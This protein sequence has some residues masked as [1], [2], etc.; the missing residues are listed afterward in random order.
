MNY[1]VEISGQA[2]VDL[3]RVLAALHERSPM[4][5]SRLARKFWRSL[6]RLRVFPLA[7]GL[8]HESDAFPEEVRHLLFGLR[9]GRKYRALFVV[10]G[11]VAHVLCIRAPGEKPVEPEDLG[12]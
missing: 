5:A 7:C 2:A 3:D 9:S 12:F 10:R 1:R 11:D 6:D 4:A 8:A